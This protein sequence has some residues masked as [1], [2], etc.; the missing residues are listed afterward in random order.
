MALSY[1]DTER[2][3]IRFCIRLAANTNL[4]LDKFVFGRVEINVK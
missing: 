2:K 4:A 3:F 1:N